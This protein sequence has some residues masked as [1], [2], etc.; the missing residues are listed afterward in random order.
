MPS[1]DSRE[2]MPQKSSAIPGKQSPN[3]GES[4]S[5]HS[6]QFN[7]ISNEISLILQSEQLDKVLIGRTTPMARIPEIGEWP[8]EHWS[9]L[10]GHTV[11]NMR[12]MMREINYKPTK[13]GSSVII[14]APRFWQCLNANR[15]LE[16]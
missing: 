15:D 3:E 7:E 1:N 8:L 6:S 10:W 5:H 13:L 16:E 2:G 14:N 9:G 12:K 11:E 4:T